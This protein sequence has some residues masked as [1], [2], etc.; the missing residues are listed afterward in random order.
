MTKIT[1]Q[2]DDVLPDCVQSAIEEVREYLGNWLADSS[3]LKTSEPGQAPCLSN[4]LDYGGG[5]HEIVDSVVPHWTR[6]IEAAWFL[7]GKDL[8]E[9][10]ENAGVGDNPREGN[11]TAAIYYYIWQQ[12][13]EW[14]EVK[15]ADI[16]DG[17]RA[18]KRD[19]D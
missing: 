13:S 4:D 5:I 6:D 17:Y 18:L 12:V 19:E 2:I 14:Y 9:S 7:H 10:Y 8:E 3:F 15:A 1:V 16:C 11:G